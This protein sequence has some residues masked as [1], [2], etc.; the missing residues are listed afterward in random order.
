MKRQVNC[1]MCNKIF[2]IEKGF[3]YCKNLGCTEYN[4]KFGK[5]I[6]K[7]FAEEEE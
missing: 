4:K 1:K 2:V 5:K 7:K 6:V 3:R